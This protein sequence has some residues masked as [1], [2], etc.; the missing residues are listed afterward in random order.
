M[1]R[2]SKSLSIEPTKNILCYHHNSS[3]Q[4]Q[5]IKFF[6]NGI[7]YSS[8]MVF[9]GQRIMFEAKPDSQVKI[10]SHNNQGNTLF[11]QLISCQDLQV[12]PQF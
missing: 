7:N 5:M 12:N 3:A 8:K 4:M 9:P 10:L 11:S 6:N 2:I 1:P